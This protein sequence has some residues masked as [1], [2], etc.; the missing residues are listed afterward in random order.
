MRYGAKQT[1]FGVLSPP[2]SPPDTGARLLTRAT[3]RP[4]PARAPD[5]PPPTPRVLPRAAAFPGD[6]LSERHTPQSTQHQSGVTRVYTWAFFL[7][8]LVRPTVYLDKLIPEARHY[9]GIRR[10]AYAGGA[11]GRGGFP[12]ATVTSKV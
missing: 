2:H 1:R 7:L 6:G 8:F 12:V 5:A 3:P 4:R 9:P 10:T 11:G